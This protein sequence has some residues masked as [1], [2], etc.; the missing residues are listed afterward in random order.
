M[1]NMRKA[2]IE[3]VRYGLYNPEPAPQKSVEALQALVEQKNKYIKEL[4]AIVNS[5]KKAISHLK[6]E[7]ESSKKIYEIPVVRMKGHLAI[8][9]GK[10]IYCSDRSFSG[11]Y[12]ERNYLAWEKDDSYDF[13]LIPKEV[14]F[15][16]CSKKNS[17]LKLQKIGVICIPYEFEIESYDNCF[18]IEKKDRKAMVSLPEGSI[19]VLDMEPG[20]F[21]LSY[22]M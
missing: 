22:Y 6:F 14:T 1:K 16:K 3:A 15:R 9:V 4:I 17:L 12:K 19:F 11:Y 10:I 20:F 7:T 8:L 18:F 5:Q 21:D 13:L 2:V